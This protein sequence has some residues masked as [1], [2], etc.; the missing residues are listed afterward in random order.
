MNQK[1]FNIIG[2]NFQSSDR[3][4]P[5]KTCVIH[6]GT[7]LIS[8]LDE[9]GTLWCPLC[10]TTYLQEDTATDEAM[11]GKFKQQQTRI[12]SPR[13]KA[14][15]YYDKQG[16]LITDETL[17]Q[18]IERGATVY[19]YREEKSGKENEHHVVRR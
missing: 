12:V 4:I 3:Y 14:K 17:I 13:K 16:N 2:F 11:K 5:S 19:S 10:G 18:D 8:K 1:K 6:Y 15:K 7:A 9:P